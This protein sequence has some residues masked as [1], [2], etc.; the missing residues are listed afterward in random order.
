MKIF[1]WSKFGRTPPQGN[2]KGGC[3]GNGIEASHIIKPGKLAQSEMSNTTRSGDI[4]PRSE[5]SCSRHYIDRFGNTFNFDTAE[6]LRLILA[7]FNLKEREGVRSTRKWY[8]GL[9][10]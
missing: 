7:P 1:F 3:G 5:I 8:Q 10:S 4:F 6:F 2:G 9:V